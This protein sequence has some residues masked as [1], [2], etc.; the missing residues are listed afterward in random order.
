[1]QGS[2]SDILR[3]YAVENEMPTVHSQQNANP[4]D[5]PVVTD[6]TQSV[7]E[8]AV[9]D[10]ADDVE[11]LEG[12]TDAAEKLIDVVESMESK[13]VF[14]QNLRSAGKNLDG[15]AARTLAM[16]IAESMEAR[17]IP[18]E[19][20]KKEMERLAVS[21]ESNAYDYSAEAE[22]AAT[23][24]KDRVVTVLKNAYAAIV[25]FL[26]KLVDRFRGLGDSMGTA[27]DR[28]Q[29]LGIDLENKDAPSGV[30]LKGG[31]YEELFTNAGAF[32]PGEAFKA[33][34]NAIDKAYDESSVRIKFLKD[35][36]LTGGGEKPGALSIPLTDG[37][38]IE[39]DADGKMS[40]K[41]VKKPD[42]AKE[43]AV[44]SVAMIKEMGK[45]LSAMSTVL[46]GIDKQNKDLIADLD[47]LVKKAQAQTA[48]MDKGADK[49]QQVNSLGDVTRQLKVVQSLVPQSINHCAKVGKVAYRFALASAARYS[50]K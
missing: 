1:M 14:L 49:T 45:D 41:Q 13:I 36:T 38:V 16:G 8:E 3:G 26:K 32:N 15:V 22:G 42:A 9:E 50:A 40:T 35:K 30:T 11:E 46:H 39:L 19:W 7:L 18:V 47:Q 5:I 6:N 4:D 31:T 44:A 29:K 10:I 21:F 37:M 12:K 24:I 28:L 2:L 23:S 33:S 25:E 34:F 48:A 17:N 20:Y 43:V 27:G